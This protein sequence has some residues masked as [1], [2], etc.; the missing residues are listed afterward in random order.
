MYRLM[1]R[2]AATWTRTPSSPALYVVVALL[3]VFSTTPLSPPIY[4]VIAL[5]LGL[6]RTPP[7]MN[8]CVVPHTHSRD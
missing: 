3:R 7:C 8:V 1:L 4:P 5:A 2:S 6:C